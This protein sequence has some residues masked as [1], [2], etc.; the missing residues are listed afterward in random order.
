MIAHDT[1]SRTRLVRRTR[2]AGVEQERR[3]AHERRAVQL[4]RFHLVKRLQGAGL[5]A[6]AIMRATGI[7]RKFVLT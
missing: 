3:L 4:E 5:S 7:G 6:A 1:V 2:S